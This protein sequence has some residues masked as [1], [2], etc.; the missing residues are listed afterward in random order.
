MIRAPLERPVL[1]ILSHVLLAACSD[2]GATST[3]A[4]VPPAPS[5]QAPPAPPQDPPAPPE[6]P[7]PARCPKPTLVPTPITWNA[8]REALTLAYRN[9]HQAVP[10]TSSQIVPK[11]VVLHWTAGTRLSGAFNTFDPV[12]LAGRPKLAD[13]GALNVS[14][15][16][17][18]EQDG[19]I[20]QLLPETTM[21]RHVI[22]LNHV[23]IGVENVGGA[24]GLPL[25]EAQARANTALVCWLSTQHDLSHLIGHHEYRQMEGHPLFDEVDPNYRTAKIDPGDAFMTQVREA[26]AEQGV[27]L[28][29]PDAL[30]E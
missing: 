8:E 28:S 6:D 10:Q 23:A 12:T 19:T 21:A 17:L 29:G 14:A 13:A 27:S 4:P 22:G 1:F 15:H 20:H 26:L 16:F 2:S 9:A 25:S 18:V 7:A 30:P 11:M 3:A 5:V 24:P